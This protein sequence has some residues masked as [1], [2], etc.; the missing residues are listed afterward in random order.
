LVTL[1]ALV[2]ASSS[3][4]DTAFREP[5]L[6]RTKPLPLDFPHGKH[7]NVNCLTCHHNFADGKGVDNCIMC[8]KSGRSDLK[9]QVQAQF[10]AFCF[11]CHR[12]P[13]KDLAAHGPV[14]G[15]ASCHRLPGDGTPSRDATPGDT[16]PRDAAR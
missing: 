5:F 3:A 9:V 12:H 14:A 11:E 13:K 15:C 7:V 8:H 6:T 2:A 1:C 4:T 10:H 16:A